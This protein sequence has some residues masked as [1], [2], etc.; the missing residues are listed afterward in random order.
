MLK[1]R[2]N[3]FTGA[4]INKASYSPHCWLF[5]IK[6]LLQKQKIE[7]SHEA[8]I[9]AIRGLTLYDISQNYK[10]TNNE[11]VIHNQ[12]KHIHNYACIHATN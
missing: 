9:F 1:I 7:N 5:Q 3:G 11:I 8:M 4:S 10:K 2:T 6:P 12:H